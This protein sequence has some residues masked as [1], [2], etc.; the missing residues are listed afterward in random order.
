LFSLC[1]NSTFSSG[2]GS[3]RNK[4]AGL[5]TSSGLQLQYVIV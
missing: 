5:Q 2:P 4:G 3:R 1:L